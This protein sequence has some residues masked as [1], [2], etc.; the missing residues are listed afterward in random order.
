MTTFTGTSASETFTGTSSDDTFSPLGGTDTIQG[1]EGTDTVIFRGNREDYLITRVGE[2]FLIN[3]QTSGRDETNYV[4]DVETFQ[5]ADVTIRSQTALTKSWLSDF[6]GDGRSDFFWRSTSSA[7]GQDQI[8]YIPEGTTVATVAATPDSLTSSGQTLIDTSVMEFASDYGNSVAYDGTGQMDY[9]VLY[10]SI[11]G[12]S[13]RTSGG[14][15]SFSRDLVGI[16]MTSGIRTYLGH[17]DA[18]NDTLQDLF[19]RNETAGTIE[20]YRGGDR[21]TLGGSGTLGSLDSNWVTQGIGD[22]NGDG[23]A[24]ML[25]KNSA[26][27]GIVQWNLDGINVSSS[28]YLGAPGTTWDVIGF[29][30]FDGSGTDDILFR[31]SSTGDVVQWATSASGVTG[32]AMGNIGDNWTL[33][34][35]A[36]FNGD[37]REDLLWKNSETNMVVNW[38]MDG[39]TSTGHLLSNAISSTLDFAGFGDYD[40]SGKV[41][42]AWRDT[43]TNEVSVWFM[44]GST[45]TPATV[46][47][48]DVNSYTLVT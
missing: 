37:G 18:N 4:Y 7:N 11:D 2:Y 25:F 39:S 41:D 14:S 13:W 44:D 28:A 42:I 24:D 34:G 26:T 32:S 15:F 1:G 29:Y 19:I 31:N 47:S 43:S 5:F 9:V 12:L 22:M 20:V 17:G 46:G 35:A 30:D 40:G 3:D 6:N 21:G 36:D 38:L 8:W 27:G 23:T 45:F 16:D 33:L 10:Q 48:A